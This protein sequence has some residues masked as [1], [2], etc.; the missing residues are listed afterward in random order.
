MSREFNANFGP[1][2]FNLEWRLTLL[3]VILLPVLVSLGFWQLDRAAE[4]RELAA[5]HVRQTALPPMTLAD[6][7]TY[8]D[9]RSAAVNPGTDLGGLADR[10]IQFAG[11]FQPNHY[12]LQDNRIRD[13]QFGYELIAL[14]D[15]GSLL[16]PL[17][18]G[19]IPGDPAR[20]SVP[21]PVLP[22]VDT[23]FTGRIYVPS[24]DV[25]LLAEQE[26][27]T[28]LPVVVQDYPA[29]DFAIPLARALEKPV[30]P[31]QIRIDSRHPLAKR[32]DW[33]LMNQSPE[34]HTGYAVQWFTMSAVLLIAFLWRSSNIGALLF[35][36][37]HAS[38]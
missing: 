9:E 11:H 26:A 31:L 34:K 16:V 2:V 7:M 35:P 22:E 29:E 21:K 14:V 33:P 28:A 12:L 19:W 6:V 18:L 24:S 5:R 36:R 15:T 27:P 4:K 20:R 32:A 30:L 17:N 8:L 23:E 38:S 13:G 25:Y 3:T 1:L 10:A 37:R